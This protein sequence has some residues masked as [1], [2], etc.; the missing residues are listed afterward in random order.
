MS[1]ILF[2]TLRLSRTLRDKGH[3]T[4]DQADALAEALGDA[5]QSDIATKSDL[6]A[7]QSSLRTEI[8]ELK[9]ELKND[10]AQIK[11]NLAETKADILKWIIGA[12]GFQTVIVIG[13]ILSLARLFQK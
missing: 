2:D 5:T 3:F 11:T 13:T 8:A 4:A 12:I 1:A 7:V 6:A 9:T 10:I